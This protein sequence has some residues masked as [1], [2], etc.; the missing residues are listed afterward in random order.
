MHRSRFAFIPFSSPRRHALR[1]LSGF[2]CALAVPALTGCASLRPGGPP[3]PVNFATGLELPWGIGFLPDGRLLATERPGRLRVISPQGQLVEPAV[4]GVPAVDHREHGGL[5]DVLVDR[6]FVHNRHV[7]LSYTEAGT[8]AEADHNGMAVARGRLS[9][10]ARALDDVQVI[11]RQTPKARSGENL[12]GRMA[13]AVDGTLFLTLGERREDAERVK[14]Q[15]LST[16]HGKVIR[17]RT[18]G[19]VPVGN[20]FVNTPGA[21][22]EI[23]SYGHRNPQGIFLHP[24]SGEVW[25][26]EHGPFGG[27]EVNI[28]RP[29]RNYGWPVI[30]HGCEYDSCARIGEGHARDGMEQPLT[31]WV[32][33]AIAPSN[34]FIY[35]GE[36]Y[37]A[38]RGDLFLGSLAGLA[39]WRLELRGPATE[40]IVARRE[41]LYQELG[42]RI[43][44]ARQG[45]D[46]RIY[47]LTD[48]A[49]A[50]ILRLEA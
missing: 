45:P 5:M 12:G 27:D 43:R 33:N 18:D 29:G 42:H 41:P 34:C 13:Q 24:E 47:L 32:P 3:R 31:H 16:H 7:Y 35:T 36:R 50:S 4:A 21:R 11:F 6:E 22:P 39:L 46:G 38:W 25:T 19:T 20:P 2:A 48:G 14:A 1:S 28:T 10:D 8:A 49:P 15:D 44:D 37:P 26:C 23:W 40:P 17:I 30:S 9:I